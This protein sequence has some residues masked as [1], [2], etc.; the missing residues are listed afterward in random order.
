MEE[1]SQSPNCSQ[2]SDSTNYLDGLRFISLAPKHQ[3]LE[4]Q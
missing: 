4:T 1:M 2:S 3:V